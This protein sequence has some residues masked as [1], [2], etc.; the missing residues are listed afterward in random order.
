MTCL[1]IEQLRVAAPD[2]GPEV[3]GACHLSESAT[4][5]TRKN[6]RELENQAIDFSAA[7]DRP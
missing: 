3:I 4:K 2:R 5:S 6:I 1:K 7:V